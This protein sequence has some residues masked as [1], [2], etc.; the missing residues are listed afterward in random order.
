M[1]TGTHSLPSEFPAPQ[2]VRDNNAALFVHSSCRMQKLMWQ[3]SLV[4][5]EKSRT[6]L[7]SWMHQIEDTALCHLNNPRQM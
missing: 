3:V 5:Q 2:G 1:Q 4:L 7:I 6:T